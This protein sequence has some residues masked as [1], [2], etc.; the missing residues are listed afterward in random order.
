MPEGRK[1]RASPVVSGRPLRMRRALRYVRAMPTNDADR[2]MR[3]LRITSPGALQL[4]RVP[5]PAPSEREILVRVA[6]AALNRA[7]IMQRAGRYP[8]PPGAP[9]DIPGLEFAGVVAECGAQVRN[10]R[11]GDRVCGLVGG[12]A[13]AEYLTTHEDV[14]IAVPEGIDLA[15]AAAVP[16]AF[17]T[18]HDALVTQAAL[19]P[20]E[21]VLVFAVASG[22]GLAAVHLIRALGGRAYGATRSAGKLDRAMAEGLEGGAAIAVPDDLAPHV[23]RWTAGQGM[24][25]V[26]DLVGG[27]WAS[28]ALQALAPHGRLMCI[29]TLAGSRATVDLRR[30]LSRRLTI[31]GTVLR[32]RSLQEKI[33]VTAAF[34]RDVM[35][36]L[37]A[38]RVQPVIDEVVPFENAADA[39]DRL[40]AG[41]TTGKIVLAIGPET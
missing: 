37:A 7:D 3:A 32:S 4:G 17:I 22:V 38:G 6:A 13:H 29:G 14:A 21:R 10:W 20:G 18:A 35:P 8:A 36:L 41:E 2:A 25:I 24:D 9:A 33:A 40:E 1:G 15:K 16:E 31:R 19:R 5:R 34:V 28:A 11:V 39:Y 27:D 12:G 23:E 30:I 26:L